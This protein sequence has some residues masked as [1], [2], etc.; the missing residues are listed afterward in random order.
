MN[1]HNVGIVGLFMSWYFGFIGFVSL[2]WLP[3]VLSSAASIMAIVNYYFQ[4]KK[5]RTK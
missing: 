1:D 3:M 2:N 5:N 4:I